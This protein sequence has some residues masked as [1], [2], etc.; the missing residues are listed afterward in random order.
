MQT[1][2][3]QAPVGLSTSGFK[4]TQSPFRISENQ[5]NKLKIREF[6]SWSV[7]F[8]VI[9]LLTGLLKYLK[10]GITMESITSTL[11]YTSLLALAYFIYRIVSLSKH[12]AQ[13]KTNPYHELN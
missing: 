1:V 9:T 5:V 3:E 13:V 10:V 7:C 4:P 8:A 12:P 11:F 6:I 2:R